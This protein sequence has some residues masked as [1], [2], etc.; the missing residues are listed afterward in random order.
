[1]FEK[2]LEHL[3]KQANRCRNIAAATEDDRIKSS[4]LEMAREYEDRAERVRAQ[5]DR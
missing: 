4:V 2:E 1:M 5:V 3:L